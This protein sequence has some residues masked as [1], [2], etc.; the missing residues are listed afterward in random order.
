[1]SRTQRT[2]VAT[3]S[4]F[5]STERLT[6]LSSG[7]RT[8]QL[9][10]STR[11]QPDYGFH[12]PDITISRRTDRPTEGFQSAFLPA[13]L[14]R[15]V[16]LYLPSDYQPKYSYPLV[17]MFH[18]DGADEDAAA[19][20]IPQMSRRN[21]IA[22]C[23]RG[24]VSLGL[25]ATGRPAFAWGDDPRADDYLLATVAHARSEFNI[26]SERVYLIG[27]GEGATIAYRLGIA[28]AGAVAGVVALNGRMPNVGR[29]PMFR[30]KAMRDLRVFVGHGSLNPIIPIA[31]ARRD[32]RLL[33]S[34]GTDVRFA[35]YRTTH[36]IHRTCSAT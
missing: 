34:A 35:S 29:R 20:L 1:M 30:L 2:V 3:D 4:K 18:A 36:R 15:P 6:L 25:S 7:I 32:S 33:S 31:G 12:M 8:S 13:H 10:E 26:H 24:P 16:R 5:A 19:R 23:P 11:Y 14:D 28:M 17:V 27:V 21:Y 22:A 9:E